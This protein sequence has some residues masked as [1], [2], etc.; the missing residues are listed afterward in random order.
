[1]SGKVKVEMEWTGDRVVSNVEAASP[2]AVQAGAQRVEQTAKSTVAVDTGELRDSI[3]HEV[4]GEEA[5][6]GAGAEHGIFV[7]FG[8]Y[9]MGAQPFLRPAVDNNKSAVESEIGREWA[10]AL[11]S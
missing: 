1:V 9:K 6:I 2:R 5:R 8:T 10:N 3:R 11:K 7:E 4:S